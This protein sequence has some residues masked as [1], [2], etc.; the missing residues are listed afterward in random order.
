MSGLASSHLEAEPNAQR[1][2]F[3]KHIAPWMGR[4]FADIQRSAAATKFYRHVG[5]LGRVFLEI[6]QQAFA[7]AG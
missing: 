6:E 5:T 4:M 2:I 1:E 3:Q 7:L